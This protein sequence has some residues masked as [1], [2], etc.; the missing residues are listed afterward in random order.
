MTPGSS[1]HR[2]VISP[3]GFLPFSSS[4]H[5]EQG[6]RELQAAPLAS[7]LPP[8]FLCPK[9]GLTPVLTPFPREPHTPLSAP[10]HCAPARPSHA[11]GPPPRSGICSAGTPT[12]LLVVRTPVVSRET[13]STALGFPW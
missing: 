9:L 4:S 2:T 13:S 12:R 7:I 11:R 6:C 3:P 8:T 10:G 1:R 5:R